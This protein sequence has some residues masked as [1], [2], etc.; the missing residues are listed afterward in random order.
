MY[1]TLQSVKSIW[2]KVRN[3]GMKIMKSPSQPPLMG[4]SLYKNMGLKN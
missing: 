2:D 1:K 3:V 4:Y